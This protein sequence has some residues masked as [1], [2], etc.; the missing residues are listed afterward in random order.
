M[1]REIFAYKCK[2]CGHVHYP[3][4][5]VCA[6]C[7]HLEHNEFDAVPLPKKGKLVTFTFVHNLPADFSVAKLG[8]CIVE[9]ENGMRMTGQMNIENP[10]IGMPVVGKTEVVR[11]EEFQK[12]YGMVFYKA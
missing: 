11:L 12:S 5:M 7:H 1:Q 8:L 10:K 2:K 3:Y 6:K 4:R 9:L